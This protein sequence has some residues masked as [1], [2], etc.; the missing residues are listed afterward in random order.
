[1]PSRWKRVVAWSWLWIPISFF[2]VGSSWA[3]TSPVGSA[4]DDDYHLASIWCAQGEREGVCLDTGLNPAKYVVTAGAVNASFC[5]AGQ[6][7]IT[8]ECTDYELNST[9]LILTDRLNN[10]QNL[11]PGGYYRV[12]SIFVGPDVEKSVYLM[13]IFNVL[14]TSLL[15]ALLLKFAPRA[16]SRAGLF[17]IASTF[18]PLGIFVVASTNPSGWAVTGVLF[19]LAFGLALMHQESWR[20]WRT[21]ILALGVII[22]GLMAVTSRVDSAAFTA[23]A[24]ILIAVLSG[25][26]RLRNQLPGFLIVL[27]IALVGVWTYFTVTPLTGETGLGSSEPTPDLFLTNLVELPSLVQGIVGGWPLG[28]NDTPLPSLVAVTGLL[29]LGGMVVVGLTDIA[30]TRAWAV[31]IAFVAL[32]GFPLAFMQTQGV[33]VGE[34]IQSRYL[35][36]LLAVLIFVVMLGNHMA[37]VRVIP[38]APSTVMGVALWVSVNVAL[39]ANIHRYAIGSDNGLFE[40]GIFETGAFDVDINAA[41]S[42]VPSLTAVTVLSLAASGVFLLGVFRTEPSAQVNR[43]S[44]GG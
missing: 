23:L 33:G 29:V 20:A 24:L 21:Y 42:Y 22:S 31:A 5:F 36:P 39:W 16:I 19:F 41:W 12:L 13:R 40:T 27:V 2:L 26:S 7:A 6:P 18:I 43:E 28:W 9:E 38:R 10:I 14:L 44:G 37:E 34:V 32:V 25:L 8:G 17:A 30:L 15:L 1:M 35:L 11:Y 3:L 4:P